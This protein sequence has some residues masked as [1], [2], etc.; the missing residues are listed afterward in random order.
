[1]TEDRIRLGQVVRDRI[2]GYEGTVV[3]ITHWLYGCTRLVLQASGLHEG[4]PIESYA[5]D[6]PQCDIVNKDAPEPAAPRHGD[7]PRVSRHADP[8]R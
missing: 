1:M 4:K 2:T 6:E 5:C 7:R 3:A 8:S